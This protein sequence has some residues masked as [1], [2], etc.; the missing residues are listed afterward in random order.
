MMKLK[1]E[2]QHGCLV[3][4]IRQNCVWFKEIVLNG[5]KEGQFPLKEWR[6]ISKR[7]PLPTPPQETA[8]CP[9]CNNGRLHQVKEYYVCDNCQQKTFVNEDSLPTNCKGCGY[10]TMAKS[11]VCSQCF[12]VSEDKKKPQ[13]P[14]Q[15]TYT[16]PE[17]TTLPPKEGK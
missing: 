12:F 6:R 11:G 13:M 8:L 4:G 15:K 10:P 16:R 3:C 7:Q 14:Y 9:K 1:K 17:P 5:C 2:E